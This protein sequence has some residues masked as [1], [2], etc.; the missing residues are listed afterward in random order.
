M[1]IM[2]HPIKLFILFIHKCL[3]I[4]FELISIVNLYNP[5]LQD[6]V[7]MLRIYVHNYTGSI[8]NIHRLIDISKSNYIAIP[9]YQAQIINN[10]KDNRVLEEWIFLGRLYASV[11]SVSVGMTS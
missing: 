1:Y 9:T 8:R 3:S 10:S 6:C 5:Q 11:Y 2:L 7:S 4:N